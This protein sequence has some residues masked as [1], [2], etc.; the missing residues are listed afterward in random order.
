SGRRG[1][2]SETSWP[3]SARWT[4]CLRCRIRICVTSITWLIVTFTGKTPQCLAILSVD[5]KG[6]S[7]SRR[8]LL[9]VALPTIWRFQPMPRHF[10]CAMS[11][12][13]VALST[14]AFAGPG[15]ASNSGSVVQ[16]GQSEP[17]IAPAARPAVPSGARFA[18]TG[19]GEPLALAAPVDVDTVPVLKHIA[20]TGAQLLELGEAHGLRSVSAR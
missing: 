11:V 8:T 20:A 2:C 17:E 4:A 15:D 18:N 16:N 10:L 7:R 1:K 14:P 19:Q 6:I 13:L 3:F 5:R 12:S 9:S